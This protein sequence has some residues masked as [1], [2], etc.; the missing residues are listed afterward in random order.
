[1]KLPRDIDQSTRDLLQCIFNVEPNCRIT[2]KEMMKK[3]FFRDSNWEKIRNRQIDPDTVPYKS[4]PNK[5]RYLLH[6]QYPEI[7]NLVDKAS[8]DE[9]GSGGSS[10]HKRLLGD[11][12]MHKVNK[13]FENF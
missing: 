2:I 8:Q 12:S 3:S 13:E 7:S 1:M 4:N 5:Y 10:P 11:F 6:N 9:P